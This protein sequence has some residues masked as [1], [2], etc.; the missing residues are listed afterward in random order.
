M[1]MICEY[2]GTGNDESYLCMIGQSPYEWLLFANTRNVGNI[3]RLT[4]ALDS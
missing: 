3:A 1:I 2:K 4:A